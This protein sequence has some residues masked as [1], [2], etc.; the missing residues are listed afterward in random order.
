LSVKKLSPRFSC[1]S[2][3]TLIILVFFLLAGCK[4]PGKDTAVS[5]IDVTQAFQT[6]EARLTQAVAQTP[7]LTASPE[8]GP[9]TI[10]ETPMP[11]LPS[12]I[13]ST[14]TPTEDSTASA[15]T[16]APTEGCYQAAAGYPKIDITIDDDTEM[17]PG[18]AFTKIWRVVNVGSCTW[19]AD[20]DI[21]FFSGELMGAPSSLPL[22]ATVAKD[23]SVDLA[24]DMVA[25]AGSGTYQGNWKIRNAA[26]VLFG[27]GPG[28]ESPF[29]V[30]IK[31]VSATAETPTPT[32]TATP[33]IVVQA[34]GSAVLS[35]NDTL[36][37]DTLQV[38]GGGPDLKYRTT[39][40]DPRQQLVPLVAVT[41]SVYG[42]SQPSLANCQAAN[43]GATPIIL[44][45]LSTGTYLCYRTDLG[46]PGWARFDG[47]DSNT[48]A[49]I[50]QILTWKLP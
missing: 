17:S 20:Y 31:V 3:I 5:E 24:I 43:L 40:I 23:Q 48:G 47:F 27:I 29:W 42:G 14:L 12:E 46:L 30:R 45:N 6:V 39:L 7:T 26:G 50:L 35:V 36:D 21:V 28:S 13:T 44:D 10:S 37:L 9:P 33:T 49:L 18:Q 16:P 11:T 15:N 2:K 41:M 1:F 22:N 32:P 38:N 34:S 19:T 25:P 8:P 4:M